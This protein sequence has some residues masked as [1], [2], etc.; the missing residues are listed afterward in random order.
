MA[1]LQGGLTKAAS[2]LAAADGVAHVVFLGLF[3]WRTLTG[4]IIGKYVSLVAAA[5]ALVGLVLGAAGWLCLRYAPGKKMKRLG[6]WGVGA[7]TAL[8]G[9]LLVLASWTGSGS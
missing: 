3:G 1:G 6:V 4:G 7:S 2:A 9:V 5:L 8:A